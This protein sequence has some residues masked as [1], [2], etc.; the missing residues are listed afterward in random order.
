MVFQQ[1]D[2]ALTHHPG[3]AEYSHANFFAHW[4]HEAYAAR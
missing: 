2:K 1:L 4:F 3:S